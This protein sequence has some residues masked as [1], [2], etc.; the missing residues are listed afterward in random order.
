MHAGHL[1]N[2]VDNLAYR[3]R[4]PRRHL[5]VH[6][7]VSAQVCRRF[8]APD[9]LLQRWGTSSPLPCSALLLGLPLL[10]SFPVLVASAPALCLYLHGTNVNSKYSLHTL[11]EGRPMV[12]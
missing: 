3:Y 9:L 4:L 11:H 7:A 8:M 5:G 1:R 6:R 2:N 12:V 10:L